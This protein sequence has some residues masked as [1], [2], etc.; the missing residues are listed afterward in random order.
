MSSEFRVPEMMREVLLPSFPKLDSLYFIPWPN[1][2][3]HRS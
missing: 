3:D 1:R 2:K